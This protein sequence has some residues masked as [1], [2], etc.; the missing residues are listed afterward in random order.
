MKIV[1]INKFIFKSKHNLWFVQLRVFLLIAINILWFVALTFASH[2]CFDHDLKGADWIISSNET[3]CGRYFN[4]GNFIVRPGVTVTVIPWNSHSKMLEVY[5]SSINIDGDIVGAP[6]NNGDVTSAGDGQDYAY[7]GGGGG[8]SYGGLGGNGGNY[9][10]S[11][12]NGG[13]T[14]GGSGIISPPLSG[15]DIQVGSR[16]GYSHQSDY[17][18]RGRGGNAIILSARY[19][20]KISG[21]VSANGSKGTAGFNTYNC[22]S[23]SGGGSGGGIL[24]EGDV[25]N[26]TGIVEAKGGSGGDGFGNAFFYP[27]EIWGGG[28][29]GGGRIKIFY[30]TKN[31]F[32]PNVSG[33]RKGVGNPSPDQDGY[34][35]SPGTIY[36]NQKP[37]TVNLISSIHG[38]TFTQFPVS[39]SWE[40]S[41]DSENDPIS[42]QL[43]ISNDFDF[44]SLSLDTHTNKSLYQWFGAEGISYIRVRSFDGNSYSHWSSLSQVIVDVSPPSGHSISFMNTHISSISLNLS[45]ATDNIVGLHS[46]PYYIDLSSSPIF[47]WVTASSGW[48][49]GTEWDVNGLMPST[50]YYFRTKTRDAALNESSYILTSKVTLA[51]HPDNIHVAT[52]GISSVTVAWSSSNPDNPIN[53]KYILQ[54]SNSDFDTNTPFYSSQTVRY[55][56]SATVLSLLPNTTYSIR[57]I[58]LNWGGELTSSTLISTA[59]LSTPP[60]DVELSLLGS[61][62][63]HI[64]WESINPSGTLYDLQISTS[65]DFVQIK[66]SSVTALNQATL[67]NNI[68]SNTTYYYRVSGR[69]WNGIDAFS[70]SNEIITFANPPL[71]KNLGT[72]NSNSIIAQWNINN[73][74]DSTFYRVEMS[75][76]SDFV[77]IQDSSS[78]QTLTNYSFGSLSNNATYW[79]RVKARNHQQQE[80]EYTFLGNKPTLAATPDDPIVITGYDETFGLGYYSKIVPSY[81]T[82]HPYTQIAIQNE[83][84]GQYLQGNG[85]T[86]SNPVW[87]KKSDWETGFVTNAEGGLSGLTQHNYRVHVRNFSNLINNT[88]TGVSNNTTPPIQPNAPT[89]DEV[90][91]TSLKISINYVPGGDRYW[92]SYSTW[93]AAPVSQYISIGTI[94]PSENTLIDDFDGG[95]PDSALVSLTSLTTDQITLSWTVPSIPASEPRYYRFA[96]VDNMNRFGQKSG[97]GVG[98]SKVT[99]IVTKYGMYRNDLFLTSSTANLYLDKNLT[100][101]TSYQYKIVAISNENKSGDGSITNVQYTYAEDPGKPFGG[102]ISNNSVRVL[103]S[104]GLNPSYTEYAV[105]NIEGNGYIKTDGSLQASATYFSIV[106]NES[107]RLHQGLS[108]NLS[109]TYKVKGRNMAGQETLF[110]PVSN[111]IFT[112]PD[113]PL[114]QSISHS[115]LTWSNVLTAKFTASKSD[116]FHYILSQSSDIYPT[117]SDIQWDGKSLSLNLTS[118][119]TWYLH[120]LGDNSQHQNSG[121]VHFGPILIDTTP[122]VG[123]GI[124]TLTPNTSQQIT[125]T[126]SIADDLQSGTSA[127]Y[128]EEVS[129]N[130]GGSSSE[131]WGSNRKFV[132]SGL[133]PNHQYSYR[134]RAIDFAGNISSES[135]V[136]S[137]YTHASVPVFVNNAK[138]S[139]FGLTIDWGNGGNSLGTLYEIEFSTYSDFNFVHVSTAILTQSATAQNLLE[140]SVYYVRGR[141]KNQTGIYTAYSSL[142]S[143]LTGIGN[144]PLNP[145]PNVHTSSATVSWLQG[146]SPQDAQYF[147][148]ASSDSQFDQWVINS[149]WVSDYSAQF[150]FLTPNTSYYFRIK[151]RNSNFDESPYQS[152]NTLSLLAVPPTKSQED[153]PV[154]VSS[155]TLKFVWGKANNPKDTE[156]KAELS[157]NKEFGSIVSESLWSNSTYYVSSSLEPDTV[158]WARVRSRNRLGIETYP[159]VIS[160]KSTLSPTANIVSLLPVNSWTSASIA[161]F[162]ASGSDH[163]HIRF[164]TNPN[165]NPSIS[166]THWNGSLLEL[167]LSFDGDWY[168]HVR[169]DNHDHENSGISN[170]GAIRRDKSSPTIPMPTS[171]VPD[172]VVR[173]NN[174]EFAWDHSI[175]SNP[176][177][178]A[179]EVSTSNDFTSL[180]IK[181][182]GLTSNSYTPSVSESLTDGVTY[183]WRLK[184]NDSLLNSSSY[185]FTQSFYT[186]LID[187][188]FVGIETYDSDGDGFGD[189]IRLIFNQNVMASSFDPADFQIFMPQFP[190]SSQNF[191]SS[192]KQDEVLA[193]APQMQ[194]GAPLSQNI[195]DGNGKI[196]YVSVN[197]F[198]SYIEPKVRYIGSKLKSVK[199]KPKSPDPEPLTAVDKIGPAITNV[200]A[201]TNIKSNQTVIVTAL[202][203]IIPKNEASDLNRWNIESPAGTSIPLDGVK[204]I[205]DTESLT[206]K[207]VLPVALKPSNTIQVSGKN[208]HDARGN[209]RDV[210]SRSAQNIFKSFSINSNAQNGGKLPFGRAVTPQSEVSVSFEGQL[211]IESLR[212]NIEVRMVTDHSGNQSNELIPGN[213]SVS[214]NGQ[215]GRFVPIKPLQKG[216]LYRVKVASAVS[217]IFGFNSGEEIVWEFRTVLDQSVKNV[218][219]PHPG[220]KIVL[221][222]GTFSEDS[223]LKVNLDPE[224]TAEHL[225]RNLIRRAIE[226]ER[227]KGHR[228]GSLSHY[229]IPGM[230]IEIFGEKSSGEVIKG[231]LGNTVSLIM[232]YSDSNN[233]GILDGTNP[234]VL[235]KDLKFYHLDETLG[236]FVPLENSSVDKGQKT[237]SVNINHF[238]VFAVMSGVTANFSDIRVGPNPWDPSQEPYVKIDYLKESTSVEVYMVTGQKVAS[239][240]MND[241]SGILR[242]DG[243]N[244]DGEILA[245]GVYYLVVKGSDGRK[246]LPLTIVR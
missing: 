9:S 137:T 29:G 160:S 119:S 218:V 74:P 8:G 72:L 213:I 204:T 2:E 151:S 57:V 201:K 125:I 94:T 144:I 178:Y 83:D 33:G 130:A 109:Y 93:I 185:S 194:P 170:I 35:G 184:A 216:S 224:K 128:F 182:S 189:A 123:L 44:K 126:A 19:L 40:T 78:W 242:W 7:P 147:V 10:T 221:A 67:T 117:S 27:K 111:S 152:F 236:E 31:S 3:I 210:T 47:A 172:A 114:V 181:K 80:T 46:L 127:Y 180:S 60:T 66:S 146:N 176:V 230:M 223:G 183:F 132:D 157:A 122:P 90:N 87:K 23:G 28:G 199:G 225:D 217:D 41:Y 222:P 5:A 15:D 153:L 14:Y 120:V 168:L 118:G 73:N 175:D 17:R 234:P 195:G 219:V 239:L 21:L 99:P 113:L 164:T 104:T 62:S 12:G 102:T 188:E 56:N 186:D 55:A 149:G 190:E 22:A 166:D 214:D 64:I 58:A 92:V 155:H 133:K 156:F 88:P 103:F 232:N 196:Y 61:T 228:Y 121:V 11:R 211:D 161:S 106:S 24:L 235:A 20:L 95:I 107:G 179:L 135:I 226:N 240:N 68:E 75:S 115:T 202:S 171:P 246:V 37:S 98:S 174:T 86:G 197:S 169:S 209:A 141:S 150:N 134:V 148:E 101:N 51:N 198:P 233:D 82:N 244:D 89:I 52:L 6:A 205:Y 100:P 34:D 96:A 158:Y 167:S 38:S 200:D 84:S 215:T 227:S 138:V 45:P 16:G 1:H 4:V 30:G 154:A 136:L 206:V 77:V 220:M 26:V 173:L 49:S 71:R 165:E 18:N 85:T 48:K 163:Y 124:E 192:Q 59:T 39:L 97:I 243:R 50:T 91:D 105:F 81:G 69:N 79:F 207:F 187:L 131:Q 70:E 53:S 241:G 36:Y 116:H 231:Q 65:Q 237:V 32:N 177:V 191:A 238:S 63:A 162:S 13:N 143:K 159:V 76:S 142:G 110:S 245:S 112:L 54:L 42:Y 212:N 129:G 193:G 208:L 25:I 139:G 229:P 203:E 140:N 145:T 43:Q 108:P